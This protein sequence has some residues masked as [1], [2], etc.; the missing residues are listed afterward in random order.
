MKKIL[1]LVLVVAL[2]LSG[3]G[4]VQREMQQKQYTATFLT[5][6]DTVTTIV[7]KAESEELFYE[8]AKA[9]HDEL[10]EYHS[11]SREISKCIIKK[12]GKTK[13]SDRGKIIAQKRYEIQETMF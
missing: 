7:G 1:S 8:K 11:L 10:E 6:F 5:L 4:N 13:L 3:C 12:N 9:V 2:F